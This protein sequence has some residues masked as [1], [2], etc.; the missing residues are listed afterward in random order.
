MIKFDLKKWLADNSTYPMVKRK[1]VDMGKSYISML[2]TYEPAIEV[3]GDSLATVR[4][5]DTIE[6]VAYGYHQIVS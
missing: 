2:Y 4:D 1:P 5:G 3:E 6:R